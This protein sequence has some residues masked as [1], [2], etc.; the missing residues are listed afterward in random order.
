VKWKKRKEELDRLRARHG[1]DRSLVRSFPDLSVRRTHPSNSDGFDRIEFRM[2][3]RPQDHGL[4]IGNSH[5]Q[6]NMVMFKSELAW[7]GGKKS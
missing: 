1:R 6:G 2:R 5:K 7:A 3:D 4:L